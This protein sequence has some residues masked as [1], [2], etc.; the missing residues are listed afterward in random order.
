[1]IYFNAQFF[2]YAIKYL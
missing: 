1:M 2:I